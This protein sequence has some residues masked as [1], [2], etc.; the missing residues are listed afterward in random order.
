MQ[1]TQNLE[2]PG[3]LVDLLANDEKRWDA[4]MGLMTLGQAALPAVRDG[5]GD[6]R[7]QV[8]RWC[9]IYLDHNADAASLKHLL[10]LLH[11]PKSKVRLWAVHSI[12]CDTCKEDENPIDVL[13]LLVERIEHDES[14]RVRRMAT[15]MLST[16]PPDPRA[17]AVF[18]KLLQNEED[19]K[20]RLHA[21]NGLQRCR[22]AGLISDS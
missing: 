9:A 17:V 6:G 21:A 14:V 18:E 11:D 12:S 3:E 16:R 1:E 2:D 4:F 8:R 7:W 13:P 22:E 15:V 20:L 10:P 19:H 5:L